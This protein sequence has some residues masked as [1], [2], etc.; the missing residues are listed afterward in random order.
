MATTPRPTSGPE[1]RAAL[2]RK[3]RLCAALRPSGFV[4]AI[5]AGLDAAEVRK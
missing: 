5:R 1:F 3:A 2:Q 4:R